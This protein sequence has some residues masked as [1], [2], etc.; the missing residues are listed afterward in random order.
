[1][2]FNTLAP[3]TEKASIEVLEELMYRSY[4]FQRDK[5]PSISPMRWKVVYLFQEDYEIRYQW[6]KENDKT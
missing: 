3:K 2:A 5:F 6:E 1:M 4:K